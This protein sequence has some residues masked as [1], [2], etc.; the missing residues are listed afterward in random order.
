M[1][2]IT[3][4]LTSPQPEMTRGLTFAM[5]AAAGIAV[6]N[7]Y[8]SQPI[9]PVMAADFPG[10]LVPL[11]PTATQLGYAL[12]LFGL[13]PLGDLLE[14]KRLI[15]IQFAALA[16]TLA[17]TALA[18]SPFFILAASLLVGIAATV[19]QQIIPFAAHLAAPAKRGA[20]IGTVM[21]GLLCGI[22]LSRTLSGF[23]TTAA[24]WRVMF[25][26]AVVMVLGVMVLLAWCLPRS[27]PDGRLGYGRLLSS[28]LGLWRQYPDLRRAAITQ[29]LVFSTFS[30]FWTIL[31][32]RLAE[33]P[34]NLGADIAGL[35]G[36]AGAVGV[37]AAPI[38]GRYADR[39]GPRRVIVLGTLATLLSWII[40]GLWS[41]LVGMI[42]GVVL[43]DF[44]VQ[45]VLVSHQHIVFA[46]QPDA[47]AR[48]N[49]ILMGA[50]FLG[51]AAGAASASVLWSTSGWSAISIFGGGM[52][53]VAT[54]LQIRRR[55]S[56]T[57]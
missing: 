43:L 5:A 33:P 40:F 57:A 25:G 15:L 56:V 1:T 31:A 53:L 23:V 4:P 49:T 47:R 29:A 37:L 39:R 38:A 11:I 18:P 32:L 45:A 16:L 41:S 27:R 2:P 17:A 12:G 22:L 51:G 6:A 3:E 26:L 8:Y 30:A 28:L 44:A 35:F 50:M 10:G 14:R 9:L 13:V 19:T 36:I 46:L 42:A 34:F 20:T 55:G 48:L 24:G 54:L 52:A 21:S 7:I